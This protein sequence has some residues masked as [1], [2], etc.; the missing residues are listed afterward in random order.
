MTIKIKK[1]HKGLLHKDTKTPAGKKIPLSKIKAAE[2]SKDKKVR[3]R[4]Q[5]A[6][7]ARS[8]NHKKGGRKS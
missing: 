7:N 5:F 8:F 6:D 1:S 2:H 4:A 3:A